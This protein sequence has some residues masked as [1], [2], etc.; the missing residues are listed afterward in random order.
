MTYQNL[1]SVST[2]NRDFGLCEVSDFKSADRTGF[3][4]SKTALTLSNTTS[5]CL[6]HVTIFGNLELTV[7]KMPF[8]G[9]ISPFSRIFAMES[10][11][12][13][14]YYALILN[15]PFFGLVKNFFLMSII[16]I[17][18]ESTELYRTMINIF[19]TRNRILIKF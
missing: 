4:V 5:K 2:S 19:E 15:C 7:Q 18:Y 6:Q 11:S 3:E 13:L 1:N 16:F 10:Q 8:L 17:L 12:I 14:L 9:I